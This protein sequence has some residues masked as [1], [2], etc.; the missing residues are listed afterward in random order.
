MDKYQQ[1]E[2]EKRELQDKKLTPAE[3]DAEIRKLVE[4][5]GV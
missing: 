3:Y 1:Y 4:R 5:L 2:L